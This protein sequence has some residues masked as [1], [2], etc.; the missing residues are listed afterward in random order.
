MRDTRRLS[1]LERPAEPSP[2]PTEAGFLLGLQPFVG[3]T[4]MCVGDGVLA[5]AASGPEDR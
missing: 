1:M 4:H 5:L 3:V 2:D